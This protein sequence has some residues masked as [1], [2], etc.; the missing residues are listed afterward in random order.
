M[1]RKGPVDTK[2]LVIASQKGGCSKTTLAV[3]LAVYAS[4]SGRSCVLVDIDPQES[5]SKWYDRREAQEPLLVTATAGNLTTVIEAARDEG[6]EWVV[7]DTPPHA[8]GQIEVAVQLADLV[9]VPVKATPMDLDALPGTMEILRRH[10]APAGILLSATP[11]RPRVLEEAR[12]LL[13][14][15][16]PDFPVL[17]SEIGHRVAYVDALT[18]G[19]AVSEFDPD[20]KAAAEI[21][22]V[23]SWC[24][25]R[26][27]ARRAS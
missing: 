22:A 9:L 26:L 27:H 10:T 25:T 18:N 12:E 14:A 20:S 4:Q 11:P 7:V 15:D 2:V 16:Y 17:P 21:A 3:H 1:A 23:Y 6:R 19:L 5:A 24:N 13:A 8:A